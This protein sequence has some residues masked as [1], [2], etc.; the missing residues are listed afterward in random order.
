MKTPKDIKV[1]SPYISIYLFL[2]PSIYPLEHQMKTTKDIKVV[3]I[4]LYPLSIC[5][6]AR[7]PNEKTQ[8]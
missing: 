6:P 7:K 8:G 1:P 5:P 2:N 3:Y 4:H